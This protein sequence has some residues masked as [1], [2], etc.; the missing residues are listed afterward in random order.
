[1]SEQVKVKDLE[2]FARFRAAMIKFAQH[3]GDAISSADSEVAGTVNWLETEQRTFWEGQ[4]RK[5]SEAVAKAR[6]DLRQKKLYKDSSGRTPSA[7]D[8]EKALAK[9]TAA[10][11]H[12]EERLLNVRR[13]LPRLEKAAGLYRSGVA[14]LSKTIADD[15][16]RSLSLLDRLAESLHQYLEIEN[17][18]SAPPGEA[19]AESVASMSRGGDSSTEPQP[20]QS[21]APG[22]PAPQPQNPEAPH[23]THGQ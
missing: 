10:V 15:I 14:A 9:A 22:E 5:R 7:V 13:W 18:L 1:M 8:Q 2:V 3:A 20:Q 23:V 11:A 6:E 4:L 21:A 16:P 12:A 19:P 17:A